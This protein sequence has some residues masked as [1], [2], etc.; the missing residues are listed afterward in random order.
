MLVKQSPGEPDP[1]HQQYREALCEIIQ[2]VVLERLGKKVALQR[3]T[4]YAKKHI[5]ADEQEQF[6]QVSENEVLGLHQG[7]Y[8]RYRIKPVQFKAWQDVWN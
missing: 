8:V 2:A 5:E 7:N 3:I 6:R 1:F 4:V